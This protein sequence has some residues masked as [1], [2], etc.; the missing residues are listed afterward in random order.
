MKNTLKCIGIQGRL[1]SSTLCIVTLQA[2]LRVQIQIWLTF[3]KY[4]P[5]DRH[6]TK[7]F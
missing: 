6:F 4:H 5:S 2:M 7:G 1:I 3:I